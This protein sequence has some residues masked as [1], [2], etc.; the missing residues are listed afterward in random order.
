MD[1]TSEI[2][3]G[4]NPNVKPE[5]DMKNNR[6]DRKHAYSSDVLKAVGVRSSV[7]KTKYFLAVRIG[8]RKTC[9]WVADAAGEV[10]STVE[11]RSKTPLTFTSKRAVTAFCRSEA[12]PTPTFAVFGKA[13]GR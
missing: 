4:A 6:K 5:P 3:S 1:A 8:K 2:H 12:L 11:D 13:G 7:G 9:C 10:L